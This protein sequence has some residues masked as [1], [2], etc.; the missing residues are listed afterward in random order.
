MKVGRASEIVHRFNRALEEHNPELLD[1]IIDQICVMESIQPAPDGTQYA[2]YDLNLAF[3]RA[4]AVDRA[5]RFESEDIFVMG[6]RANV[7][8]RFHFGE[9]GSVRGSA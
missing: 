7:R 2:G 9:G 5:N 8:W 1:D 3:W 6:D 4:M